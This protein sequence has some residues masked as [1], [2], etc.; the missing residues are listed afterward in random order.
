[1]ERRRSASLIREDT[2][3]SSDWPDSASVM[4]ETM[5]APDRGVKSHGSA[6]PA[7][8]GGGLGA[9]QQ[10]QPRQVNQASRKTDLEKLYWN[11]T[12]NGGSGDQ[13]RYPGN[14]KL[15][16]NGFHHSA[17]AAFDEVDKVGLWNGKMANKPEQKRR[18]RSG[19]WAHT[20]NGYHHHQQQHQQ[21]QQALQ[22]QLE[23]GVIEKFYWNDKIPGATENEQKLGNKQSTAKLLASQA[24]QQA[25][26]RKA[27]LNGM[28]REFQN[29]NDEEKLYWNEKLGSSCV[30]ISSYNG[31]PMSAGHNI[32]S[33]DMFGPNTLIKPVVGGAAGHGIQGGGKGAA[34]AAYRNYL[35]THDTTGA[36]GGR[37][38]S[39]QMLAGQHTSAQARLAA[40]VGRPASSLGMV[41][42]NTGGGQ[43][44]LGSPSIR[45]NRHRRSSMSYYEENQKSQAYNFPQVRRHFHNI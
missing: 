23:E 34:L 28:S 27:K 2:R 29:F 31:A 10:Q 35:Q 8:S 25:N 42:G 12:L 24:A 37:R 6:A 3:D 19:S 44:M 20:Q 41:T 30:D 18:S 9:G 32:K 33:S 39:K 16:S 11:G 22:Q 45:Y 1:M 26:I 13:A 7:K 43:A 21:Q 38:L 15:D 4:A 36:P 5:L 40:Y 17:T 14:E